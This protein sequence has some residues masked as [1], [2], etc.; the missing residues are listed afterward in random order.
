MR[1]GKVAEYV[2]GVTYKAGEDLSASETSDMATACP[3]GVQVEQQTDSQVN[4]GR[5]DAE[6]VRQS[7]GGAE[8]RR[9]GDGGGGLLCHGDDQRVAGGG[10]GLFGSSPCS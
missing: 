1:L 5:A 9:G 2:R 6:A 7:H 3:S 10:D 4:T 8:R